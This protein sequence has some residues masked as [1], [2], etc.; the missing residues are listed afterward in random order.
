MSSLELFANPYRSPATKA[1]L[2]HLR[3][4]SAIRSNP[5]R[6]NDN[7]VPIET[8]ATF[9]AKPRGL[10]ADENFALLKALLFCRSGRHFASTASR[11]LR[12]RTFADFYWPELV[13]GT[14]ARTAHRQIL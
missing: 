4:A 13:I 12:F 6:E 10:A 7:R 14:S 3:A 2:G 9:A 11:P 1:A 5:N 8:V